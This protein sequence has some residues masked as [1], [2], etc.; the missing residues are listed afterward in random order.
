MTFYK[1][2][3]IEKIGTIE[4][5]GIEKGM[6]YIFPKLDGTNGSIWRDG[7]FI[8]TGSRKRELGI[9]SDNAGFCKWVSDQECFDEFFNKYPDLRL[10]GEWLVPHTLKTYRDDA[11][12]KFYVFDVME[13]DR[14]LTYEEY[15]PI[16]SEFEIE[17]IPAMCK[18]KKPTHEKLF[19]LLDKNIFLIKDG[20]GS[21]EGIVI[22]NY[23]YKNRFGRVTWAKIVKNEFKDKLSKNEMFGVSEIK[24]KFEIEQKIIDKFVTPHLIEK[25][26]SKIVNES[27]WSSKFIPKLIGVVFYCLVKEEMWNILQE[28]KKPAIDFKKLNG[29]C[30]EKIKEIKPEIF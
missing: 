29:L 17:Y 2:Q 12:R 5:E 30:T 1:Y 28:F 14:Y 27:G 6:C 18:I 9:D 8:K 19:E 4:T 24:C 15:T 13:Q 10:Y 22:K 16:L 26:Y 25:E 23:Y 21:G 11:W 3:H 7:D 20:Q